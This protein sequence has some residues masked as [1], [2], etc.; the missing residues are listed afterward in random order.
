MRHPRVVHRYEQQEKAWNVDVWV[1]TDFAR[2]IDTGKSTSVSMVGSSC[3]K[4]WSVTQKNIALS[5]GEAE[6]YGIVRGSAMG[7][8]IRNM[9]EDLGVVVGVVV[10]T[11]ARAAKGIASRRGAGNIRHIEVA[12][13][14]VQEKVSTGEIKLIKVSTSEHVADALTKHVTGEGVMNHI[15][16]AGMRVVSGRSGMALRV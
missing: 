15:K 8:S 3:I 4:T 10:M 11:D 6:Y 9:Y 2:Y 7:M 13:L 5:S 14:W 12:Q 1:G 16:W